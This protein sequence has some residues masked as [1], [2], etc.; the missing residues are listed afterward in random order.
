MP[1]LPLPG[2]LQEQQTKG[3]GHHMAV[4]VLLLLVLLPQHMQ[5]D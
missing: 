1:H 3:S 5:H 4:A 2:R